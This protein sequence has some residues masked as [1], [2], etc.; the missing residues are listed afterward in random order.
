[1]GLIN[2][3]ASHGVAIAQVT[4]EPGQRVGA[5]LVSEIDQIILNGAP[6]SIVEITL[7]RIDT[8]WKAGRP[9]DPATYVP[10]ATEQALL[11]NVYYWYIWKYFWELSKTHQGC[12]EECSDP[13][14]FN[15]MRKR[16]CDFICSY[17]KRLGLADPEICPES[18]GA[19]ANRILSITV[20]TP[21]ER[22]GCHIH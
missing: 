8:I 6:Y 5:F 12:P 4:G 2:I 16:A 7:E 19:K 15:T 1:M 13:E 10:T 18:S 11:Q 21:K 9:E 14:F 3:P 17:L 22:K 20:R